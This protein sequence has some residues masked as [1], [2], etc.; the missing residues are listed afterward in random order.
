MDN[1]K[2]IMD[3]WTLVAPMG[4]GMPFL[5]SLIYTG[6]RIGG[7][8]ECKSQSFESG[9][10]FFP[11]DYS[12]TP[13]GDARAKTVGLEAM[14]K[15]GRVPPAKRPS[16]TALGTRSPFRPDWD[17]VCGFKPSEPF[18]PGNYV[19]TQRAEGEDAKIWLLH[20][21][22]TKQV[23]KDLALRA[24]GDEAAILSKALNNSRYQRGL[25]AL[26]VEPERLLRGALVSIAVTMCR[27]GH[28]EDMT[29]IY[30]VDLKEAQQW[31]SSLRDGQVDAMTTVC[32]FPRRG[33]LL[34]KIVPS[35][36]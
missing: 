22:G 27:R 6:S 1:S 7:Q 9:L 10:P 31:L 35:A 2:P 3:G 18:Q 20:S 15:W 26:K 17:V 34:A 13:L 32:T 29:C 14:A 8:R 33:W 24:A 16:Y 36:I 23:V 11:D 4:W 19:P 25:C 28:P 5:S 12:G 21:A 30:P